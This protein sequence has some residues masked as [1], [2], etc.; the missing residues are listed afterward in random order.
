MPNRPA[1]DL[2]FPL[3]QVS[4]IAEH[5]MAAPEHTWS[6]Y[7]TD[8]LVG[9]A[10][11]WVK[12]RGTTYVCSNGRPRQ[13]DPNR[14]G[15]TLTC[16]AHGWATFSPYLS[17]TAVGGDDFAEYLPLNARPGVGEPLID[18]IREDAPHL[19]WL[20][21]HVTTTTCEVGVELTRPYVI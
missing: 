7:D 1:I 16:Y 21:I 10:L 12:E 5:A 2:W 13:L 3:E 17:A 20:V 11:V 4:P 15:T 18:L 8:P 6:P 14:P 9:P 19:G